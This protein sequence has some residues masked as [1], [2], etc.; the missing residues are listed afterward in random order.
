MR[1]PPSR[2]DQD[3]WFPIEDGTFPI[4]RERAGGGSAVITE[5]PLASQEE[6]VVRTI[7]PRRE[8]LAPLQGVSE[9]LTYRDCGTIH[10]KY[11]PSLSNGE[12]WNITEFHRVSNIYPSL[13][14]KNDA[15]GR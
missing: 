7:A 10:E 6:E 11:V 9:N 15:Q 8:A 5:A 13:F 12:I 3:L 1:I 4:F 14:L 2:E